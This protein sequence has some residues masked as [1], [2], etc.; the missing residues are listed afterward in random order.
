MAGNDDILG[1]ADALLRR[2]TGAPAAATDPAAVPVLTDFVDVAGSEDATVLAG[3]VSMQVMATVEAR[4]A[5][6]IEQR[7]TQQLSGSVQ[8]AVAAAVEELRPTLADAVAHAVA[9]ALERRKV[10]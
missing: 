2:S 4:L 3:E 5:S 1:K 8:A 6:D 7:V 9:E 10:K